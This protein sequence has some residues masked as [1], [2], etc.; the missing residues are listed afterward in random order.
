[1]A[2]SIPSSTS[3]RTIP[4]PEAGGGGG[5]G[6]GNPWTSFTELPLDP[7]GANGWTVLNG[8]GGAGATL[9]KVGDILVFEQDTLTS[10]HIQGSTMKGKVMIRN[11]HIKMAEDANIPQPAG[12]AA[13]LL[14]P[15]ACNL[16]LE[17]VFDTD[18]GGPINGPDASGGYGN[19]LTCIAGLVGYNTD[20]EGSPTIP[21]GTSVIWLGAQVYKANGSQPS[22]YS[23]TNMYRSGYKT[24]F[25]NN[26]TVQGYTW[27]N[28]QSAPAAAHD[29]L[30]FTLAPIR[31]G[32][33]SG[34]NK[35]Y[36]WGGSYAKDQPWNPVATSGLAITDNTTRYWNAAGQTYW[37]LCIW[38][39]GHGNTAVRG[40]IRIKKINYVLQP[41]VG[42]SDIT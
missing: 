19:N 38:F 42:R 27:K 13:H 36:T 8:S 28:Q 34:T 6:G 3:S 2:R 32:A 39:G 22:A 31:L 9:G 20:Q 41:V 1:M 12:V 18:G 7:T 25:T 37:H 17:I 29:S 33:A 14:Q 10:M 30:V 16:K 24:Y 23:N 21:G 5:G 40:S 35:A 26:A 4:A 11:E 15:E